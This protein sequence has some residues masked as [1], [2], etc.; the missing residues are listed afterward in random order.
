M[1]LPKGRSTITIDVLMRGLKDR[2][3]QGIIRGLIEKI[4]HRDMAA[5][6]HMKSLGNTF[7]RRNFHSSSREL[8]IHSSNVMFPVIVSL[9]TKTV[10]L[11]FLKI[12]KITN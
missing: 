6:F 2:V 4:F 8:L 5:S 9:F 1:E 12:N 10:V 3:L 11:Y 7:A